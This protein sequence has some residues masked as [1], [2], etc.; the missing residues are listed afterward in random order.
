MELAPG[1]KTR[2]IPVCI[3]VDGKFYDAGDY[4]ASPVPMALQTG[5]VYEAFKTGVSQG[6]F[7]VSAA[8]QNPK[9][10]TWLGQGT[11]QDAA[12]LAA[13][14]KSPKSAG[15]A[16]KP[17]GIDQDEGPPVLRRAGPQNQTPATTASKDAAPAQDSTASNKPAATQTTPEAKADAQP[18]ST[19]DSSPDEG[20]P[21]RP[22][23]QR[24]AHAQKT[25]A[26]DSATPP[27]A[28]ASPS[29]AA[30]PKSGAIASNV[31][32]EIP[33]ISD[34]AGADPQ[35]YQ[36][37]MSDQEQSA[38]LKQMMGAASDELRKHSQQIAKGRIGD[39]PSPHTT[40]KKQTTPPAP[41]FTNSQLRVF[42]LSTSNE[43]VLV[44]A[45]HAHMAESASV[46]YLVTLVMR[47][48]VN[49]DFHKV[50]SNITDAQHL[51]VTPKMDLVDVVDADG[52]G[53]GEFL[54]R[55]TS[56]S[57]SAF[58]IYRL[59]GDELYPLFEGTIG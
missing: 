41:T 23:L 54:F 34:A 45:A 25:K 35:P 29:K 42:D 21:D 16:A 2:L 19:S 56:D 9:T 27:A 40:G 48:D 32:Q 13:A 57:G 30:A 6:L 59:I 11:W 44:F 36:F 51:D 52:D 8:L 33:A 17:K 7:T 43:P 26:A 37:T 22:T 47:E 12:A 39:T 31:P 14:A 46:E 49:G 15:A 3:L 10:N 18:N 24:G 4:K 20:D 55:K 1:G 5:V 53:R 58:V 50:L 28:K 38:F